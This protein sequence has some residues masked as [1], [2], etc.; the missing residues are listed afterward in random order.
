MNKQEIKKAINVIQNMDLSTFCDKEE[1]GKVVD[2]LT[3]HLQQQLTNGWIPCKERLP[4]VERVYLISIKN[5][6]HNIIGFGI[7][8]TEKKSWFADW[9]KN[10]NWKTQKVIVT[11]WQDTPEPYKEV[12]NDRSN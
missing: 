9:L 8:D 2:V 6:A 1:A 10:T 4:E 7:Y 5:G 11:A 3:E 12:S